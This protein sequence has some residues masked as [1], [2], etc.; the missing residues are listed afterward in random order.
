M[1]I[2]NDSLK[3]LKY[4]PMSRRHQLVTTLVI[5]VATFQQPTDLLAAPTTKETQQTQDMEEIVVTGKALPGSVIGDIPPEN[6]LNPTDIA[7]YGVSTINDLLDE[8]A[9]QTQ[10]D[11]GR[12]SSSGPII[13]V[14]GKRVSGVNEVGDLPTESILRLDILPEE[15]ALKYGYDAQQKVVNLILRRYFQAKV[16]NLG[17]GTSTEGAGENEMGDVSYNRIR[18]NNRIN[19][20][21][22]VKSQAWVRESD[23]DVSSTA[24]TVSDPSG[25]IGDDSDAR[26]LQPATRT[27]TLNGVVAHPLS[28]AI[29]AS[30][31]AQAT[32][33][34]SRALDGYP[35]SNLN[36]PAS[37]PYAL[38]D[39]DATVERYLSDS[40][41]HQNIDT[42]TAHAG[43]TLNADLPR[44]WRFSMIGTYDHIDE[45]TQADRG[46]DVTAL[47]AAIDAGEIDPYGPLPS[48]TLGSL[49]RQDA[50]AITNAGS[51]S[52]LAN[53]KLFR[54]P[55]GDITTSMKLGGDFS[56][57]DSTSTGEESTRSSRTK[58]TGRISVAVP[59]TSRSNDV[60]G[61]IGNLSANVTG[62]VTEVSSFGSLGTFGYGLHWTPRKDISIIASVNE[63]RQAPTLDQ[64]NDPIVTTTNIRVYDYALGKTVT[65]SQISGGNP[66]LKAD[67]R[68]V[69]KLGASLAPVS[70]AKLKLNLTANYIHSVT[71]NAIG[72]LGSATADM[73][74]AFPDRF[75]RD[76]D[77]MLRSVDSRAVNFAREEREQVRWGFNL[78]KVLRAP[79]RPTPPPGFRPPGMLSRQQPAAGRQVETENAPRGTPIGS[80]SDTTRTGSTPA[81]NASEQSHVNS[82]NNGQEE[83]V[84]TGRRES[85]DEASGPPP[86]PDG[87]GPP[88]GPPP[89]G[90]P[91]D[92]P[93]PVGPP[94]DGMGPRPGGGFGPPGGPGGP[95]GGFGGG[96]GAQLQVSAYHS[97]YF[98]DDVLLSA[99]G[100]TV[101][102][103]NG[104]TIGA[105]GQARHKIQLNVGVIDDGIG[106]RFSGSWTSPTKIIDGGNGSGPL[107]YSS[108]ATFDVRLFANLQQ[109]FM[110]KAWAR[111]SH[112]TLAVSNLFNARQNVHDASGATPQIYQPAFL[113]PYGRTVSISLRRLF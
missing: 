94:P 113:D 48:S 109:R 2:R 89:D 74:E 112:L 77:G 12:D 9:A 6:Q 17:G 56:G 21:T 84:V 69:L 46:Y 78:T 16:A 73:E 38:S 37:S 41:L 19:V 1:T 103:L 45:H 107:Y 14:N 90:F 111:G 99:G 24:G 53:G 102:L 5:V 100:P 30:F 42:A 11:Q 49:R 96:N 63:D 70:T 15:V 79:Q 35:S 52:V 23:R 62:A 91:P 58:A 97:W 95:A 92:G 68:R 80:E 65:V 104:G 22:R 75:E 32:Y 10:S 105:G 88:D 60:L 76:D 13:L 85:E 72:M 3:T 26:T 33:K 98:Q 55:A 83:I 43:V 28:D 110:G 66:D 108:L 29:T 87:M 59:L 93:P 71:R 64:L 57:L 51:A 7:S 61:A 18:D 36:V 82:S 34:T 54:L 31:N 20:V 67:K 47:Q 81:G 101:D 4:R 8:I 50:R 40:T 86:L 39:S 106:L 44:M 27:Y 25:T